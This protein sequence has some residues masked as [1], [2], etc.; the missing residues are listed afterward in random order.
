[1]SLQSMASEPRVSCPVI[2]MTPDVGTVTIPLMEAILGIIV[3]PRR[4]DVPIVMVTGSGVI[5]L[6]LSK[7]SNVVDEAVFATGIACSI[8]VWNETEYVPAAN[9]GVAT[10]VVGT[11]VRIDVGFVPPGI[12]ACFGACIPIRLELHK[13][14][15]A[16]IPNKNN[17]LFMILLHLRLRIEYFYWVLQWFKNGILNI[18]KFVPEYYIASRTYESKVL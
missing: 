17:C 11:V 4:A 7:R 16:R 5:G 6:P 14:D 10:S 18:V 3:G 8:Q 12:W 2:E 15:I 9:A 13:F 1:M